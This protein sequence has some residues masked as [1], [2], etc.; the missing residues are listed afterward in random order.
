MNADRLR[1]SV[2]SHEGC[3][4]LPYR[5]TVGKVTIGYG[6]NLTDV[7]ISQ[8]EA[9]QMLAADLAKAEADV[10]GHIPFFD[11]LTDAR[12]NALCELAF[13]MG[14]MGLL[15]FHFMLGNL[16]NG[17]YRLAAQDLAASLWSK[18]VGPKRS[19][20]IQKLISTGAF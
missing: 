3:R 17:T 9:E 4:L 6:R 13:N 10:R 8:A 15:S 1:A 18:Q 2:S 7:G 20:D 11:S 12:Q 14:I 16:Q 19:G 5:D